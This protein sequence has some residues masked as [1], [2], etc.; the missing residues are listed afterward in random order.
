M[1]NGQGALL[2]RGRPQNIVFFLEE[3]LCHEKNKKQ[4]VVSRSSTKS[5]CRVMTNVTVKLIWIRASLTE[6]DFHSRVSHEITWR[7]KATRHIA[8]NVVFH[9]KT[10][11]IEV[12]CHI[13]RKKLEENIIVVKHV[14][15]GHQL[16]DLLTKA[17]DRTRIDF[18]CN[19]LDMYDIYILY[20]EGE[21]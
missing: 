12:D 7:N 21:R 3:I 16:A 5:Q 11:H 1:Q 15:S 4:S 19:K 10:K 14:S 9:E 20:F 18:I 17:L 13:V 2:I 8:E 6:I